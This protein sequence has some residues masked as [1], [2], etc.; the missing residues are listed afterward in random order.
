MALYLVQIAVPYVHL[1]IIN[2]LLYMLAKYLLTS[3][4]LFNFKISHIFGQNR[5]VLE[6]NHCILL[7]FL[8]LC[9]IFVN[10]A[11]GLFTKNTLHRETQ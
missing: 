8:K 4:G 3:V 6:G 9:P 7:H 11:L 2:N 10:S 1:T 5:T